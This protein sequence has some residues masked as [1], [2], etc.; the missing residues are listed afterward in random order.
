MLAPADLIADRNSWRSAAFC[1]SQA[2]R[3]RS[4]ASITCVPPAQLSSIE[5]AAGAAWS[6]GFTSHSLL[7]DMVAIAGAESGWGLYL[8]TSGTSFWGEWQIGLPLHADICPDLWPT[9]NGNYANIWDNADCADTLYEIQGLGAWVDFIDHGGVVS[10]TDPA[11]GCG[12]VAYYPLAQ[13]AVK[14][15]GDLMPIRP[16]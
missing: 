8:H 5:A 14:A 15:V 4:T 3:D 6:A 9:S 13:A 7:I 10:T 16:L 12:N 2:S 11:P 1:L